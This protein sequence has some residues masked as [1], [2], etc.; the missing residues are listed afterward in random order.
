[1]AVRLRYLAH[2][3][4]VPMG[5]FLIGRTSD[6]QLSLD[7]ALVSRRHALLTVEPE[8]VF[9]ED[10]ESRNGVFLN[11][12][13]IRRVTRVADGDVIRVGGQ[14]LTLFG[15][16]APSDDPASRPRAA[17]RL[18]ATM[19]DVRVQ[20]LL[21]QETL[22]EEP[23]P[24]TR[25]EPAVA[26]APPSTARGARL[27][28]PSSERFPAPRPQPEPSE[29][30]DDVGDATSVHVAPL[31]PDPG[32]RVHGL[33]LIG[34]VADKALALGRADEA[35]RILARALNDIL[36]RAP[37]GDVPAELAEKA[38]SYAIRLAGATGRGAWI[39]YTLELYTVLPALLPARLVDELYAVAR[40]VKSTDKAVLRA[41]TA[42]L[43]EMSNGFG[44]AERFIQ[45]RIESFERWAP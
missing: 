45:Q 16:D 30:D 8:G 34:S 42:R 12:Q 40:K 35:E 25:P 19:Q 33:S 23:K 1:M 37:A 26:P 15:I 31:P 22:R 21:A 2:D 39:N 32:K 17:H 3:L 6:C 38:A 41:Y 5:E 29:E 18:S 20:D 43:R 7:D 36:T 44:P 13:R 24:E 14:E 27:K 10:L 4:E 9:I 11:G 28:S